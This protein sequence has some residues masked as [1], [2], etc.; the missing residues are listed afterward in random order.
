MVLIAL[1]DQ[2]LSCEVTCLVYSAPLWLSIN[3]NLFILFYF[4]EFIHI[5]VYN[6]HNYLKIYKII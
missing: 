6:A 1:G 4:I 5:M 3:N 2:M